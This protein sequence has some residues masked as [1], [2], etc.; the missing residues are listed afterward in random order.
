M[1]ERFWIRLFPWTTKD[2]AESKSAQIKFA[3]RLTV[4]RARWLAIPRIAVGESLWL[5]AMGRGREHRLGRSHSWLSIVAPPGH[6]RHKILQNVYPD[7]T[8][9]VRLAG[10]I[11]EA[12]GKPQGRYWC[13]VLTDVRYRVRD[14]WRNATLETC[15]VEMDALGVVGLRTSR[16]YDGRIKQINGWFGLMTNGYK[17]ERRP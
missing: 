3:P 12:A 16:S 10:A 17:E 9:S 2:K 1:R 4:T 7:E 8:L 11:Y 5:E 15:H 13:Q 6:A 14:E